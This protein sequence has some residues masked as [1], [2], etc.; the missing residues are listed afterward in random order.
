MIREQKNI[1]EGRRG[2]LTE[3]DAQDIVKNSCIFRQSRRALHFDFVENQQDKNFVGN[4]PLALD[5]IRAP[6][7]IDDVA[8]LILSKRTPGHLTNSGNVII[9]DLNHT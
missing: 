5:S 7:G 8:S 4:I 2:A 1:L 6:Q 3:V 9:S